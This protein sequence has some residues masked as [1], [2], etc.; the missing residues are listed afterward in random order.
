MQTKNF[1]P[2]LLASAEAYLRELPATP[3][4]ISLP[5][6][7]EISAWIDH[8]LLKPEATTAQ[9]ENLCRE[10]LQY[11]FASVCVNPVYV[12][13]V[14]RILA[15]S[16]VKVCTVIGFPLGASLPQSKARE[17]EICIQS[18]A[19]ELDMVLQIGALKGEAYSLVFEDIQGVVEASRPANALVKVILETSAL[20][21]KE[22]II[23]CLICKAAGVDF[24]KTS[25]GFGTGGAT[26]KDVD[27]MHRLVG[28]E[29]KVKA[30]GGIRTLSDALS[31]IQAGAS[32]LGTSSGVK[33]ISEIQAET[34]GS[35]S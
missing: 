21:Q 35:V 20:V 28:P 10:A 7:T 19:V 15:N 1:Y 6:G 33:I 13:L 30:S 23:A 14:S 3:E 26:I 17:A 32:R 27:L 31:M 25:T 4:S 29:I 5:I 11:Q 22:I 12:P 16:T 2:E 18:G 8:T 9:I 24:V 34:E